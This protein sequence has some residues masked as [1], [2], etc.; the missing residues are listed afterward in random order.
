MQTVC[1]YFGNTFGRLKVADKGIHRRT[2][3][4]TLN[5]L[6]SESNLMESEQGYVVALRLPNLPH[7]KRRLVSSGKCALPTKS[8]Q[9]P[10]EWVLGVSGNI[11]VSSFKMGRGRAVSWTNAWQGSQ[12][13]RG[14][15]SVWLRPINSRTLLIPGFTSNYT[16]CYTTTAW[17]ILPHIHIY[18]CIYLLFIYIPSRH[19]YSCIGY[20]K[21]KRLG[22]HL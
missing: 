21:V 10:A 15:S 7:E 2:R 13:P 5:Y 18:I 16:L 9:R 6:S 14:T 12:S 22:I 8:L 19:L 1:S 3:A 11:R 17:N 20:K 4:I